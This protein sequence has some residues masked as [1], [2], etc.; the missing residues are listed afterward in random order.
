[1]CVRERS[2]WMLV[3]GLIAGCGSPS[4][5]TSA[6]DLRGS[7]GSA[8]GWRWSEV[9]IYARRSGIACGVVVRLL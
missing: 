8:N 3:A 2:S 4:S 9:A 7:W 5:P 6:V 1:M